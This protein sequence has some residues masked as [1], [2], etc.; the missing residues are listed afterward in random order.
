MLR[1]VYNSTREEEND[2]T[3][4]GLITCT[5][6]IS[7]HTDGLLS[8]TFEAFQEPS[9]GQHETKWRKKH[10][11]FVV[12]MFQRSVSIETVTRI[13]KRTESDEGKTKLR[14]RP[15]FKSWQYI[16]EAQRHCLNSISPDVARLGFSQREFHCRRMST[17]KNDA[18]QQKIDEIFSIYIQSDLLGPKSNN[19]NLKISSHKNKLT[20]S[21][22][23]RS[24]R[25]DSALNLEKLSKVGFESLPQKDS[26]VKFSMDE[27]VDKEV[28]TT[29]FRP[30]R[31]GSVAENE[32]GRK[33]LTPPVKTES[34]RSSRFSSPNF[35]GHSSPKENVLRPTKECYSKILDTLK[36]I[37]DEEKIQIPLSGR[38]DSS[39]DVDHKIDGNY[40][41]S[42]SSSPVILNSSPRKLNT[43]FTATSSAV[44]VSSF[45]FD[46]PRMP[47]SAFSTPRLPPLENGPKNE[48]LENYNELLISARS[49]IIEEP[50]RLSSKVI[51]QG[52]SSIPSGSPRWETSDEKARNIFSFLD[53]VEKSDRETLLNLKYDTI[54]TRHHDGKGDNFYSNFSPRSAEFPSQKMD[55]LIRKGS[56]ELSREVLLLERK[57]EEYRHNVTVLEETLINQRELNMRHIK[58]SERDLKKRLKLQQEEFELALTRHQAFVDQII[59][60]KRCLQDKC[61][62]I[63]RDLKDTELKHQDQIKSLQDKHLDELKRLRRIQETSEKARRAKWMGSK[64]QEIR[65]TTIKNLEPDLQRVI[66]RHQQ[67]MTEMRA[68]HANELHEMEERCARKLVKQA[69]EIREQMIHEKDEA[70]RR[71]RELINRS[72]SNEMEHLIQDLETQKKRY[73]QDIYE[74][75]ERFDVEQQKV[76]DLIQ[77]NIRKV[78]I[79]S[80]VEL[81]SLK[82]Q[83]EAKILALERRHDTELKTIANVH[84]AER[85]AYISSYNKKLD[86]ALTE[87]ELVLAQASKAE[88]EAEMEE[89]EK[90]LRQDFEKQL[91]EQEDLYESKLKRLTEKFQQEIQEFEETEKDLKNRFSSAK[92]ELITK[93]EE[94]FTLKTTLNLKDKQIHE[95]SDTNMKMLEERANLTAVIRREFDTQIEALVQEC[96]AVKSSVIELKAK[97]K[98][99]HE[100]HLMELEKVRNEKDYEL[101]KVGQRVVVAMS[102]KEETIN[103]LQKQLEK[104]AFRVH[105]LEELLEQQRK[106]FVQSMTATKNPKNVKQK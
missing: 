53:E 54:P 36:R 106:E 1:L 17:S 8:R 38:G 105:H 16:I 2:L 93:E 51:E 80:E 39:N 57:I 22:S 63:L 43:R 84:E 49:V 79:K 67:E 60:E 33:S 24:K 10:W 4:F 34:P 20:R 35:N 64:T 91:K 56:V 55:A 30:I 13:N 68:W 14:L 41:P 12:L 99:E 25:K 37:E 69:Q 26:K 92:T 81:E 96:T 94:I 101:D 87:R 66:Q 76:K 48:C 89:R 58:N 103:E 97:H 7:L 3:L 15:M 5:Y 72:H 88:K 46:S 32:D 75:R 74:E 23:T 52:R 44:S 19:F 104:T 73:L 28:E 70:I 86:Q 90:K 83:H 9:M 31:E 45:G 59:S 100:Q 77:E 102:R 21:V 6:I 18:R 61:E 71:D 82:E 11:Q 95:F 85:E 78:E 47:A 62:K 98:L 50:I 27:D 42:R 29:L 65:E 40:I